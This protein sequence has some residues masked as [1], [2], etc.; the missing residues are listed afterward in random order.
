VPQ[1]ENEVAESKQEY[2]LI[3]FNGMTK[4]M[5]VERNKI[6]LIHSLFHQFYVSYQQFYETTGKSFD[7]I[8]RQPPPPFPQSDECT[9]LTP[10]AP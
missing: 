4:M 5:E 3:Y 1:W 6:H 8:V 9:L 7:A 10:H 2:D